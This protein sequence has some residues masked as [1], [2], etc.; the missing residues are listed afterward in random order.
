MEE[1]SVF[2]NESDVFDF[3]WEHLRESI[4]NPETVETFL[5][6]L[7][8]KVWLELLNAYENGI[9]D[10]LRLVM[11]DALAEEGEVIQNN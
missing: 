2:Q 7:P 8:E 9:R 6:A 5:K 1:V 3:V 10:E 4:Q 11:A